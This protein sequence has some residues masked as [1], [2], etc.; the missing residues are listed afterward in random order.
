MSLFSY[1][2]AFARSIGLYVRE[3]F[4]T[5]FRSQHM[6]EDSA[7]KQHRNTDTQCSVNAN[8]LNCERQQECADGRTE[9]A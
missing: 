8:V 5:S 4:P 6:T 9:A 3:V 1:R 7:E 2:L